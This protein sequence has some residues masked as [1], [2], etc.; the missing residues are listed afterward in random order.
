V[1]SLRL[2]GLHPRRVW[3]TRVHVVA[4]HTSCRSAPL[5]RVMPIILCEGFLRRPFSLLVA[6]SFVG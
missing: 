5:P 3:S 6:L 4:W 2:G 1:G